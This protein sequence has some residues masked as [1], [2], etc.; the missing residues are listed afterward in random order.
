MAVLRNAK[1]SMVQLLVEDLKAL[2]A[3]TIPDKVGSPARPNLAGTVSVT[4][5]NNTVNGSGTAFTTDFAVGDFIVIG[6]DTVQYRI[7]SIVNGTQLTLATNYAGATASG[8]TYKKSNFG[9]YFSGGL[10][11]AADNVADGRYQAIALGDNSTAENAN[12]TGLGN[13]LID[14][15]L[16]R[17][18]GSSVKT[19]LTNDEANGGWKANWECT[20]TATL[21][22]VV[23]EMV[24][25][26]S[27]IAN[28][29]LH[30]L[31]QVLAS[32]LNVK[33]GDKL[34]VV[35]TV[36]VTG[37]NTVATPPANQNVVTFE[38][39]REICRL[40]MSPITTR[41]AEDDAA[42]TDWRTAYTIGSAVGRVPKQFDSICVGSDD[43]ATL[44]VARANTKL[45]TE[46][47]ANGF[48]R[49]TGANVRGTLRQE[50][51]D[52]PYTFDA[53]SF[54]VFEGDTVQWATLFTS[55]GTVTIYEGG[56]SNGTDSTNANTGV[57]LNRVTYVDP[58]L[59]D[60]TFKHEPIYR[61]QA[62]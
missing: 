33:I 49:R 1:S 17:Q 45:G 30:I 51:L 3:F 9:N 6:S 50:P 18:A 39:L 8:L 28:R 2:T 52:E 42:G 25:G 37:S 13:E 57:Q 46:H 47:T 38:A 20:F 19:Y 61:L 10:F 26:S 43:G 15:G 5:G 27:S 35:L 32:N 29:G 34:N 14:G 60:S 4:N 48:T 53:D 36:K 58:L 56:V 44:V 55:T 16:Q 11:D 41:R 23:R 31:R 59:Y 7:A 22:K 12:H 62:V 54:E 24:V 40:L 21:D